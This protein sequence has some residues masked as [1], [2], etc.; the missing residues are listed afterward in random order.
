M[1][2]LSVRIFSSQVSARCIFLTLSE[3]FQ[4]KSTMCQT[5]IRLFFISIVFVLSTASEN[6]QPKIF[7]YSEVDVEKINIEVGSYYDMKH[8]F[9]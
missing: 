5:F 2:I 7:L 9:F 3:L 1:E 8:A 6:Y 4:K